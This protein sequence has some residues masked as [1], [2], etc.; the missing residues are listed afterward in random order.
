L[1]PL[2]SAAF[3]GARHKQ[4]LIDRLRNLP[5]RR[6]SR[7]AAL[8]AGHR[9]A[10]EGEAPPRL[11]RL[12]EE[13]F[14]LYRRLTGPGLHDA[15]VAACRGAGFRPNVVQEAPRLTAT[16]SL[17]AAGLGLSVVPASMRSLAIPGVV[18]RT[19]TGPS[20]LHAPMHLATRREEQGAVLGRFRELVGRMRAE[21][22]S[23]PRP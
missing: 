15:I 16:L 17:V 9:L 14:I 1:H 7:N 18:Y 2:E 21:Q 5:A 22:A 3:H 10:Q 8:P 6:R 12:A 11:S 13:P 4:T 20:K 19:L 23:G